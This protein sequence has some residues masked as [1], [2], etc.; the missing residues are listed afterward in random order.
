VTFDAP[1]GWQQARSFHH[2][3]YGEAFLAARERSV[4]GCLPAR[5][6][7]S[8][9]GPIVEVLVGLRGRGAIEQLV[10]VDGNSSAR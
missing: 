1:A 8:T 9:A 7:A 6:G 3:R 5:K 4:S 2:S 10:V